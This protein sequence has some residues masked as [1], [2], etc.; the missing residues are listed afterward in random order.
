[1]LTCDFQALKTR[2]SYAKEKVVEEWRRRVPT[3][4]EQLEKYK[5]RMRTSVDKLGRRWNDTKAVTIREKVSFICGVLNVLISGY[6]I[7][8]YA[9]YFHIWYT[10][11][12]LYFMPIRYFS[13]KKIG[14][15][16]FLADLCYFVN[17]MVFLS[18]WIFPQSKRLFISTFCLA[19]GNN[20]I[21][22]GMSFKS[23][24]SPLLLLNPVSNLS[25][26]AYPNQANAN[27]A[28]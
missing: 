16:Y 11:Q 25:T 20:A 5:T 14:F 26:Q 24:L 17:F 1:M 9:E 13:Y 18:V 21:A 12:L 19:F 28:S 2:S 4:E 22:I 3:A 27:Y 6:L 23:K 7:G 8:G 10:V 15:H